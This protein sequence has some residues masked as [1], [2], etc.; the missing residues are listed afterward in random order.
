MLDLGIERTGEL[1]GGECTGRIVRSE[2]AFKQRKV[3]TSL[4]GSRIIVVDFSEVSAIEGGG[5]GMLLFLDRWAHDHKSQ[6]KVFNPTKSVRD[7]LQLVQ[8]I[9]T[10]RHCVARRNDG[11]S[12]RS[13]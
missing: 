4:I 3:V 2:A 7:R 12:G 5:L 9:S 10:V 8:S 6:L 1:G 13:R 11:P